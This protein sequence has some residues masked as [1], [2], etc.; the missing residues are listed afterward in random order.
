[1]SFCFSFFFVSVSRSVRACECMCTST[2]VR[3]NDRKTDNVFV[4]ARAF[5]ENAHRSCMYM[6]AQT[7][8]N[9]DDEP[10]WCVCVWFPACIA[11]CISMPVCLSGEPPQAYRC[12]PPQKK[13]YVTKVPLDLTFPP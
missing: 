1:M 3:Q 5:I 4:C 13:K 12:E 2:D 11:V 9:S 6:Y 10:V 8:T 7:Y